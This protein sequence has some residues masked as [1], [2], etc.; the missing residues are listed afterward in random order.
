[1]ATTTSIIIL[2][3]NS[4]QT[5]QLII[6]FFN[7]NRKNLFYGGGNVY[8]VAIPYNPNG[9]IVCQLWSQTQSGLVFHFTLGDSGDLV[10]AD[11]GLTIGT[12][13]SNLYLV[14]DGGLL[15]GVDTIN[16]NCLT[17]NPR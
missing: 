16:N 2:T 5:F 3:N 17:I 15:P 14:T 9:S 10:I 1:M 4:T 8:S 6:P 11:T 12:V 13:A 7:Y